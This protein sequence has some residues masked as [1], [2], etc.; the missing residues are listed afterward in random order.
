MSTIYT[1]HLDPSPGSKNWTGFKS[2]HK[3][4]GKKTHGF[5]CWNM[6]PGQSWGINLWEFQCYDEG[7]LNGSNLCMDAHYEMLSKEPANYQSEM[8]CTFSTD[9]NL[10]L[11]KDPSTTIIATE[12]DALCPMGTHYKDETLGDGYQWWLCPNWAYLFGGTPPEI[13]YGWFSLE[14]KFS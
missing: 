5:Y 12:Q 6:I 11:G 4:E 13:C 3:Y 1:H 7:L 14:K 9:K 8:F 2:P 10:F